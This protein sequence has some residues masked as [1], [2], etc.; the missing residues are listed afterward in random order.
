MRRILNHRHAR[1][2]DRPFAVA[3]TEVTLAQF[4]RFRPRHDFNKWYAPT[5]ECPAVFVLWYDAAAYCNW[6][7]EKEGI[8]KDQWCYLPNKDGKYAEGMSIAPDHL[9]R[10]GYRLPTEAEWDFTCRAGAVTDYHFG[11]AVKMLAH[12]GRFDG[13]SHGISHP[14]G[15]H[16]PNDI[17]LFDTHGNAWEWCQDAFQPH[18]K[19][20]DDKLVPDPEGGPVDD[21]TPRVLRGGGYNNPPLHLRAANRNSFLPA[22]EADGAVGFRVARTMP[23]EGK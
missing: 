16:W 2:I 3:S 23:A 17:G 20:A 7:S 13:N 19:T 10:T 1:R 5:G 8:P 9:K 6:L 4:L 21:K 14:V 18:P 15:H 22:Q 11:E 12:F